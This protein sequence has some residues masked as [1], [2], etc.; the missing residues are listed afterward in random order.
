MTECKLYKVYDFLVPSNAGIPNPY[1]V[2]AKKGV[3]LKVAYTSKITPKIRYERRIERV[4][5]KLF[6]FIV[7]F[8]RRKA[9]VL[10]SP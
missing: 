4:N 10:V 9:A 7:K 6:F 3:V 8:Y 5:K 1:T 2:C